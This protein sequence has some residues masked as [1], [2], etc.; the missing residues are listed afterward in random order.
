MDLL[1]RR[2]FANTAADGSISQVRLVDSDYL[3]ADRH[4]GRVQYRLKGLNP[5][6]ASLDGQLSTSPAKVT[7]TWSFDG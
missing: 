1:Q 7:L 3:V 5:W 6:G 4:N 2:K